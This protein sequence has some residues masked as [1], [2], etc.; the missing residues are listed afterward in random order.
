MGSSTHIEVF[1]S[2][3]KLAIQSVGLRRS[4]PPCRTKKIYFSFFSPITPTSCKRSVTRPHRLGMKSRLSTALPKGHHKE[5]MGMCFNSPQ[6]SFAPWCVYT[7]HVHK[8]S[9]PP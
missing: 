1:V 6:G 2:L 5:N 7:V 4:R 8:H 9:I 3:G